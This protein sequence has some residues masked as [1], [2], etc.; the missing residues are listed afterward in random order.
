MYNHIAVCYVLDCLGCTVLPFFPPRLT[1]TSTQIFLN[2]KIWYIWAYQLEIRKSSVWK[3]EKPVHSWIEPFNLLSIRITL[4]ITVLQQ[5]LMLGPGGYAR[6]SNVSCTWVSVN[7]FVWC[8]GSEAGE[9]AFS[10][11]A[12]RMHSVSSP[13]LQKSTWS[14]AD[15]FH[16]PPMFCSFFFPVPSMLLYCGDCKNKTAKDDAHKIK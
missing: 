11:T 8:S 12:G 14:W 2:C 7:L 9:V 5:Y 13:I 1:R 16:R 4:R 15:V 10:L 3:S 6:L